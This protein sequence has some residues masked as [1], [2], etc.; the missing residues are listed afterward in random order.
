MTHGP[1]RDNVAASKS[2]KLSKKAKTSDEISSVTETVADKP[3]LIDVESSVI[4]EQVGDPLRDSNTYH[5]NPDQNTHSAQTHV[6][7]GNETDGIQSGSNTNNFNAD[8]GERYV[9]VPAPPSAHGMLDIDPGLDL[10]H[11]QSSDY[12]ITGTGDG[13]RLVA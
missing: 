12:S 6:M 9:A 13:V 11:A 10:G 3:G 4:T 2:K 1:P 8:S 5:N 7:T